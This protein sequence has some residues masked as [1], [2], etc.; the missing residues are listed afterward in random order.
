MS[1]EQTSLS[2][3]DITKLLQLIYG[4]ETMQA[5][6]ETEWADRFDHERLREQLREILNCKDEYHDHCILY[7]KIFLLGKKEKLNEHG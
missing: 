3:K 7:Q 2:K 5:D 4:T 1:E 6:H